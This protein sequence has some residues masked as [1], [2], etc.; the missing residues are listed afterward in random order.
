MLATRKRSTG[1]HLNSYEAADEEIVFS[2]CV[3]RRVCILKLCSVEDTLQL[4]VSY[5][6]VHIMAIPAGFKK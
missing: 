4:F 5:L 2:I 3:G 1:L 6:L